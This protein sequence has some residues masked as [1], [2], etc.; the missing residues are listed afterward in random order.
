[1]T[2]PRLRFTLR[3]LALAA[4][5][6]LLVLLASSGAFKA[7]V[8][9]A[10]LWTVRFAETHPVLGAAV[11]LL[12]SAVS[13]MLAFASSAVLVPPAVRVWG[14]L[15][16]FLLLW[17]GWVLGAA[18]GFGVGRLMTPLLFRAG[19]G[20]KLFKYRRFASREMGFP[21]VVLFCLAVPSELPGYLFGAAR[22]P[23]LK[24]LAAMALAESAYALGLVLI[25]ERVAAYKP[26]LVLIALGGLVVAAVLA[27][28]LVRRRRG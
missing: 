10:A 6:L 16:T 1:M 7:R 12:F 27:R 5:V 19:Y 18:A 15:A 11:F 14:E 13:A 24:F 28:I 20:K 23:F 17:G 9:A 8:D 26:S 2:R 3:A 21:A 22:Y 4:F 25:G